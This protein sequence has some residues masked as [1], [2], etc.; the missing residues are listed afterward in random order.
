MKKAAIVSCNDNYDYETRTKYVKNYLNEKGFNVVFV[1]ADFDHRNKKDYAANRTDNFEYIHVKKYK[2]NISI[3]R[4]LSHIQF[5]KKTKEFLLKNKFDLV[6]H[7]APPNYT[8]KE[9]SKLKTLH[10]YFLITEIGDMWPETMPLS[11]LYK[12]VLCL[13]FSI[14]KN[15]RDKY[16]FNSDVVIAECDLFNQQLRNNTGL[17]NIN[18]VYFCK[19]SNCIP[20]NDFLIDDKK[21]SLI[22]LGS[23]NNIIDFDIIAKLVR[24]IANRKDVEIHI[25]GDGEKKDEM[26]AMIEH[27]GGKTV[28]H[29][30]IYDDEL[31]RDIFS[32]CQYALNIMKTEVYVG[33]TMKSLDYFSFGIPLIN[34]IGADIGRIVET[35]KIGLN[36]TYENCEEVA[37]NIINM[38]KEEYLILRY[39]VQK[40]HE[41]YFSI[42]EFYNKLDGVLSIL[43]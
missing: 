8:I 25:I 10:S 5:A 1:I 31:K 23:V 11:K 40:T 36:I 9:L 34:N 17:T 41:K 20:F 14:W 35:E 18:T 33:M 19:K 43:K 4:I 26:I 16:L 39:N 28:F 42:K 7:C 32:K 15:L 21:I 30:Q 2:K 12:K 38:S 22:Y 13:P 37:A 6:Y 24:K 27:S 29:G 3:N